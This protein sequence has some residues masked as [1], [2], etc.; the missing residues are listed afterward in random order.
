MQR[1]FIDDMPFKEVMNKSRV[2]LRGVVILVF[3][4]VLLSVFS[5]TKS[6]L[7]VWASFGFLITFLGIT[8]HSYVNRRMYEMTSSLHAIF[9]WV[10]P[11]FVTIVI[12]YVYRILYIEDVNL[13]T[14]VRSL[15]LFST[16]T[17]LMFLVLYIYLFARKLVYALGDEKGLVLKKLFGSR[18]I[19]ISE[20][21]R[22]DKGLFVY[23]LKYKTHTGNKKQYIL[24]S[25]VEQWVQ[26][27]G[28]EINSVE[29][30]KE[31]LR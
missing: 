29:K 21:L 10:I 18:Q 6:Y 15:L 1:L 16:I 11:V 28:S 25:Y 14:P 9:K 20:I 3:G 26:L 4:L 5:Q 22:I 27:F 30:Y 12:I 17:L 2:V 8:Y 7:F 31:H 24:P 19:K 23:V 13:E